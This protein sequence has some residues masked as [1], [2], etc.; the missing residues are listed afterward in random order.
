MQRA[1]L[2]VLAVAMLAVAPAGAATLG[3][4]ASAVIPAETQQIIQVDYRKMNDSASGQALKQR[5]LPD[6]LR[7]FESA[8]KD[9]GINPDTQVETLTFASFRREGGGLRVLGV[10]QGQF[11]RAAVLKRLRLRKIR[12]EKVRGSFVYPMTNGMS[13][14]FLDANTLLFAD[15][16]SLEIA[17][18]TRDG[19]RAG[20]GTN[21]EVSN[22]VATV[23]A[24]TVWSVLDQSGTQHMMRSALGDAAKLA[25]Y[26]T[27]KKR[28]L[29]SYY[30]ADFDK[31]VAFDLTVMTADSMTAATL[32]SVVQA[33]MWW[34]QKMVA[35]SAEKLALESAKVESESDRL[36]LSFRAD[37]KRFQTLLNSDL[38][39]A[40]SR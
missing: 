5:V 10:A 21:T 27:V 26:E 30:A 9:V 7:Q 20:V 22:L 18:E 29:G 13:M 14:T 6:T 38:F 35:S 40:V 12:G 1:V 17:L 2:A 32:S 15:R 19:E 34:R 8:L 16:K 28:I 25:D 39:A 3:T 4:A 11:T 37:E 33:G 31:G 36:K 23:E 24:G